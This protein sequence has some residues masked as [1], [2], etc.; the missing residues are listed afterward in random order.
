MRTAQ[1]LE[2]QIKHLILV[3]KDGEGRRPKYEVFLLV[4]PV[5]IK[6]HLHRT[7][8]PNDDKHQRP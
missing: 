6:K 7:V 5:D 3:Y 2:V 8:T 1:G 4:D